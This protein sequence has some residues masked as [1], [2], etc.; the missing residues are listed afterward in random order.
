MEEFV[1]RIEP[2]A[3]M[4]AYV[5]E[6]LRKEVAA[7]PRGHQ[8][9]IA[10]AAGISRA[11]VTNILTRPEIGVG[12]DVADKLARYWGL[13]LVELTTEAHAWATK[14]QASPP[15]HPPNLA[16]ALAFIRGRG[17]LSADVER[18]AADVAKLTG[19]VSVGAWLTLLRDVQQK[20]AAGDPP[21]SRR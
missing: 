11:H 16:E 21:S 13:S 7:H 1:Q 6:R 17:G 18:I 15:T 10:R 8:A 4:S 20:L 5:R 9:H 12:T 19:D 14:H 2:R 3:A